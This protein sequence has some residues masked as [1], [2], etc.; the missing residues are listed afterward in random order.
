MT[1]TPALAFWKMLSFSHVSTPRVCTKIP[2][3]L[4]PTTLPRVW[5]ANLGPRPLHTFRVR[6][7]AYV[8]HVDQLGA[9][10]WLCLR[11]YVLGLLDAPVRH[12]LK[13]PVAIWAPKMRIWGPVWRGFPSLYEFRRF[14]WE[15]V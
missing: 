6:L 11:A 4:D 2:L 15:S 12:I 13:H 9:P 1:C 7:C 10:G 3:C 14:A 8:L 5:H